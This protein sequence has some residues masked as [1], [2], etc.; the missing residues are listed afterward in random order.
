M[1][2]SF[3]WHISIYIFIYFLY[4]YILSR[5]H[6]YTYVSN[7]CTFTLNYTYLYSLQKRTAHFTSLYFAIQYAAIILSTSRK[8]K[9]AFKA[10][11]F[12]FLFYLASN[13]V[14]YEV[15][16]W[17]SVSCLGNIKYNFSF[18]NFIIIH[19]VRKYF[20]SYCLI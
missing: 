8:Q 5:N 13:T 12:F 11:Y 15:V 6:I 16:H 7:S 20:L 18:S 19:I 3:I 4:T 2:I 9:F 14:N 1:A 10:F 17:F